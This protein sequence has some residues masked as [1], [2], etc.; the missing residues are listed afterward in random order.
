MDVCSQTLEFSLRPARKFWTYSTD[1]SDVKT[2]VLALTET[3]P[4]RPHQV[5]VYTQA[6]KCS[7][8]QISD[9]SVTASHLV[10][11]LLSSSC[12][13]STLMLFLFLSNFLLR[14]LPPLL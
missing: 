11:L 7:R 12:F 2:S 5:C 10:F 9:L 14:R 13:S 8:L 3:L 1:F 4:A 6:E